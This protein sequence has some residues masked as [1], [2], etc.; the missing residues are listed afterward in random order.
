MDDVRALSRNDFVRIGLV[1]EAGDDSK[2]PYADATSTTSSGVTASTASGGRDGGVGHNTRYM[3]CGHALVVVGDAHWP[4]FTNR[5]TGV[6]AQF[7][8]QHFLLFLIAHFQK[9]A[10]LM[11]SDQ[12]VH[13]LERLEVGN[14]DSVKRFKRAIRQRFEIFLRFTHRYWFHDISEQAH[15]QGVVQDVR[16]TPRPRSAVRRG[17]GTHPRH[18]RVPR[19][20]QPAAAG[21]H[22][23]AADRR[24][25]LRPDRHRHNRISRHEPDR[26]S[27]RADRDAPGFGIVLALTGWLTLYTIIKSKRLSDILDALSDERLAYRE[28][29]AVIWQTWRGRPRK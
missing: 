29:L 19:Q 25:D 14:P 1:T 17:E 5:D 28:K 20:R 27:G 21:E 4:F 15:G 7:R 23:R 2:L 10:L 6:L 13:A 26:G 12:L 24:H 9:A 22:R 16:R 11:M 18:G 3:C 8:H